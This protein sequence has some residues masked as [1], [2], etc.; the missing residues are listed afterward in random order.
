MKPVLH[1]FQN[2]TDTSKRENYGPMSLMN[3][4]TKILNE[5]MEN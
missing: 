2:Q 3:I 1:S 4:D 5:I